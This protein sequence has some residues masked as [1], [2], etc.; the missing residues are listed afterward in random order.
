MPRPQQGKEVITMR[1]D[2]ERP[3]LHKAGSFARVTGFL[4]RRGN[5][6]L[7]LSKN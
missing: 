6:R 4:R 1:R 2:Y 3:T 5:D 7:I